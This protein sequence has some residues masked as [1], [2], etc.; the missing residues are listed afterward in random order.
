MSRRCRQQQ[1]HQIRGRDAQSQRIMP[2]M[3]GQGQLIFKKSFYKTTHALKHSISNILTY[4]KCLKM[5]K[6]RNEICVINNN[7]TLRHLNPTQIT[8]YTERLLINVHRWVGMGQQQTRFSHQ[9]MTVHE[10]EKESQAQKCDLPYL[11]KHYPRV[12]KEFNLVSTR[13][14]LF[15]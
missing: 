6:L 12:K 5:V 3:S 7:K 4:I 9:D 1:H 10:I 14:L 11:K 2:N 8:T 13:P 15:C